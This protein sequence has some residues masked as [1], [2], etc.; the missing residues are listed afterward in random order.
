MRPGQGFIR[1]AN[2]LVCLINYRNIALN[3]T[4]NRTRICA[5]KEELGATSS[6]CG[7]KTEGATSNRG[8]RNLR[9]EYLHK[10]QSS[11]NII[12]VI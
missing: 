8:Q 11:L 1:D 4:V 2:E 12:R 10:L 6:I 7:L 9:H 3:T 5:L